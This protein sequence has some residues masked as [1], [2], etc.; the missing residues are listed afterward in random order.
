MPRDVE[1]AL[2]WFQKSAHQGSSAAQNNLGKMY[3]EG[4][5]VPK[6]AR[7]A[8]GWYRKAAEQG[9]AHALYNLGQ[10]F[11]NGHGAVKSKVVAYSLF[12]LSQA[13]GNEWA[14]EDIDKLGLSQPEIDR[15]QLLSREMNQSRSLIQ[16]LD[17]YLG[18]KR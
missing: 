18:A 7:E 10:I 2:W 1:Q 9:N 15:A 8:I 13:K 16:T 5:G 3:F 17:K 4:N 14:R 11:L 12:N 6:D